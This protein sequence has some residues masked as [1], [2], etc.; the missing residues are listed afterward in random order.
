MKKVLGLAILAALMLAFPVADYIWGKAHV[1]SDMVQ[2]CDGGTTLTIPADDLDEFLDDGACQL[3]ACDFN[4]VFMTGGACP[5]N[6]DDDE[7]DEDDDERC[8]L[9]NMR[10]SAEGRTP[11]CPPGTF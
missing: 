4:N 3:P 5:G 7:D 9:P 8:D 1:P 11:A 10:D 2:V 6:D